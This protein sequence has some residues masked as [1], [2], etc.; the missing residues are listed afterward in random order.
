M[1]GFGGLG[2][3]LCLK[4]AFFEFL[5]TATGTGSIP[6]NFSHPEAP[7]SAQLNYQIFVTLAPLAVELSGRHSGKIMEI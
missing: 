1:V 2:F 3:F 6:I 7:S 4:T 5:T